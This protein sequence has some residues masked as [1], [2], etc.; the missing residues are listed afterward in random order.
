MSAGDKSG[1]RQFIEVN[2]IDKPIL[3]VDTCCGCGDRLYKVQDGS[4]Q[5]GTEQIVSDSG[6]DMIHFSVDKQDAG[7]E[8]GLPIQFDKSRS[9][10]ICG[11]CQERAARIGESLVGMDANGKRYSV[12]YFGTMTIDGHYGSGRIDEDTRT[13]RLFKNAFKQ[14]IL[15]DGRTKQFTDEGRLMNIKGENLTPQKIIDEDGNPTNQPVFTD[16]NHIYLQK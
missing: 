5:H 8:R 11:M 7:A 2:G 14:Y 6:N 9:D 1:Q 16:G 15:N 13:A 4:R 10:F 12:F 3:D